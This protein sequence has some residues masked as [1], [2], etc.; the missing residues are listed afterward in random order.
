M[1]MRRSLL[2][3]V[4]A[5]ALL[6]GRPGAAQA[7]YGATEAGLALGAAAL[8]VFYTPCKAAVAIGG[9][10]AAESMFHRVSD[11]SK[12]GVVALVEQARRVGMTLIDVQMPTEHLASLGAVTIPRADYLRRL[13]AALPRRV[14]FASC[15][16]K[17]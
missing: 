1:R 7:G 16:V 15:T 6:A 14:A 4:L 9:L 17:P 2:V 10:F 5:L 13:A 3:P 11:A 8:N 12:I